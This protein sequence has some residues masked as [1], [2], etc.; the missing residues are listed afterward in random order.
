MRTG[1][2]FLLLLCG[3]ALECDANK[4]KDKCTSLRDEFIKLKDQAI[5]DNEARP[6]S[7]DQRKA[8]ETGFNLLR[9]MFVHGCL[10]GQPKTF[11]NFVQMKYLT[12]AEDDSKFA[13]SDAEQ[14][15]PSKWKTFPA[16]SKDAQKFMFFD[17]GDPRERQFMENLYSLELPNGKYIV[18]DPFAWV[19][20]DNPQS[21]SFACFRQKC[22]T[23]T[24]MRC[25]SYPNG[26][27][28]EAP[29]TTEGDP[30]KADADC[31]TVSAKYAYKC[32]VHLGLCSWSEKPLPPPPGPPPPPPPPPPAPAPAPGPAARP[33]APKPAP[34]STVPPKTTTHS[35]TIAMTVSTSLMI[36]TMLTL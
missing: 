24:Y 36:L 15:K 35:G 25:D 28:P 6:L 19:Y 5:P 10:D 13:C 30:C 29:P 22:G 26:P 20:N 9:A 4:Y 32:D 3:T 12:S 14:N 1:W 11:A 27:L 17:Y 18:D 33:P 8:L 34:Q 31:T 7:T 23:K 2:L 21:L 16:V